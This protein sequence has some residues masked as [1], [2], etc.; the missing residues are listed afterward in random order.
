MLMSINTRTFLA[1]AAAVAAPALPCW[2]SVNDPRQSG[3]AIALAGRLA[4]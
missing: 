3:Y 2:H 4:S 1:E